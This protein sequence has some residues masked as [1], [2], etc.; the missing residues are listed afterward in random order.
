MPF[1]VLPA[2]LALLSVPAAAQARAESPQNGPAPTAELSRALGADG[3]FLGTSGVEGSIDARDW[4]L[5]SDV[6]AGEPPRFMAAAGA[7][8]ASAWGPIGVS[9]ALRG[10]VAAFAIVGGY[11]YIGGNFT[12]TGGY[13][14]ADYVARWDHVFGN[15]AGVGAGF[16]GNGA[17]NGAV[18]GM[19]V[20]GGDLY[21]GGAFTDAAGIAA[22]DHVA[23]WN[24]TSWSALGSNEAGEG[25]LNGDVLVSAAIDGDLHIGG[26]FGDAG[27]VT[28]ADHLA[29]WTGAEWVAV[30]VDPITGEGVFNGA[31]KTLTSFGDQLY[32]GGEFDDI[33][34]D[35]QADHLARWNG[36]AWSRVGS[37]GAGGE[38]L[39]ATVNALA[40]NGN[41]LFV[42]G[43]FTDAGGI[44]EADHLAQWSGGSWAA[45]GAPASGVAALNGN[46]HALTVAGSDLYV[47]GGFTDAA[48][49]PAA[50]YIARTNHDGWS[51][52]GS[53][54]EG[55]AVLGGAVHALAVGGSV[56]Y[57]GGAFVNAAG[58]GEADYAALAEIGPWGPLGSWPGRRDGALLQGV[59]AMAVSGTDLY[60]GGMFMDAGGIPEADY[61][62][63]W[64][65]QSWTAL[66]SNAAGNG[67]L[68][69]GTTVRAITVW[70]P[71][72]YVG[73]FFLDVAGIDEANYIARWD[74]S[75]WS[76]V[77]SPGT[78]VAALSADVYVMEVGDGVLYV[79]GAFHDAAGI[80]AADSLARWDG[81]AWSAVGS[82]AGGP[83]L[84]H[85]V[86]ALAVS[87]SDL[88]VGG[89]FNDAG[90][91]A[92]ADKL[93]RWDGANWSALGSNGAGDGALNASV[94]AITV[95]GGGVYAAGEFYNV[96]GIADADFLARWNGTSWSALGSVGG[97][98]P[99]NGYVRSMKI[100]NGSLYI[101]GS[102][103]D[104]GGNS[105]AD[106]VARWDGTTW[107]SLSGDGAGDGALRGHVRALAIE[108]EKLYVGGDFTN[109]ARIPRAD[110]VAVTALSAAAGS[111]IDV[112]GSPSDVGAFPG[113][114]QAVVSWSEPASDG[115]RDITGYTV[116]S[117]PGAVT[118]SS[119]GLSCTVNGLTNGTPYSFAVRA[120]N[121]DGFGPSSAFSAAVTPVASAVPDI[122]A[123]SAA[124]PKREIVAS[125]SLGT[126]AI[127]RVSW[128]ASADPSG[129]DRYE[130][131]RRKGTGVWVNIALAT[132]TSISANAAVA[133]GSAYRFRVRAT[134]GAGNT[135]QWTTTASATLRARQENSSRI[136]YSSGF[137]RA[138]LSGASGGYVRYASLSQR[139][140]RLSFSGT[141]VAWVTT[142]AP[143]R[144]IA[145]IWLD[146]AK[147]ATIDLYAVSSQK[148]RV[149]WAS[150]VAPGTHTLEVRITGTKRAAASGTRVD[151]DAF[152]VHP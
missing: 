150:V 24:G 102:L 93:A 12:D 118:C 122:S 39:N 15:W 140:A 96:A 6:A 28:A 25:A 101:G 87:G 132:A 112:P 67:A 3:T 58:V 7:S 9:S 1:L 103:L 128:D 75:G 76:A 92:E 147:V 35:P 30:G 145:Q 100:A 19:T 139:W 123:P 127:I 47:G 34:G 52:L 130:L 14:A 97:N 138:A 38:S 41:A 56:L 149:T 64:D 16:A 31:V 55:N 104:T 79:G 45:I 37:N 65:G 111:L 29:R 134:D 80:A 77:G 23:R 83:A 20:I 36:T 98:S 107:S 95:Q 42:G 152:L 2:I 73:G 133:P 74:G 121:P 131:Q 146:G 43:A 86:T 8:D 99:V 17:L 115:G 21:V 142:L 137:R 88:Y 119:S 129:I 60:V 22:A 126:T 113:A 72:V 26:S 106:Y 59:H 61:V 85:V 90:G 136:S 53:T 84:L 70:G 117:S 5:V 62:A 141:S 116:T 110:H 125:Q 68:G 94:T 109:A 78:G 81:T 50:D 66:G 144:G 63:R 46:V 57:V 105:Q 49:I 10:P 120:S 89:A 71:D 32:V 114:G 69:P 151:V 18:H 124:M 91:I 40:V 44:V 13:A 108:G 51:A 48:G 4:V 148:R 11:L 54:G 143:R 27:G 135:G 82:Q 33:G